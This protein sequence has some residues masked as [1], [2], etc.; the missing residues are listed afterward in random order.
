MLVSAAMATALLT[1]CGGSGSGGSNDFSSISDLQAAMA[2]AG[3]PC[4]GN[5]GPYEADE[6]DLD[7]GVDPVEVLNC[8]VDGVEVSVARWKN[9]KDRAATMTL[10]KSLMCAFGFD[11]SVV[12]ESGTWMIGGGSLGEESDEVLRQVADALGIKPT[13]IS[14]D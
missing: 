8:E 12:L 9:S 4:P 6:D 1:G 11:G 14:C 2:D 3:V 5:P 10:S 7:L 13:V